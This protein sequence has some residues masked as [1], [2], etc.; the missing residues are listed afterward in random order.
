CGYRNR[1]KPLG[2]LTSRLGA[3]RGHA[4][5][6]AHGS[7]RLARGWG[8]IVSA[9]TSRNHVAWGG[10][11]P[12][13]VQLTHGAPIRE[14]VLFVDDEEANLEVYRLHF[15]GQFPM[16]TAKDGKEALEILARSDVLLV[17]TDERM[18]G[19]TGIELLG[20]VAARWPTVGRIIVSAYSD[21]Q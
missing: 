18:P 15:D 7:N 21:A 10:V 8:S 11:M 12:V 4:P 17:V 16:V 3:G 9:G 14:A 1:S 2:R 13:Q 19:M 5:E 6:F 20:H